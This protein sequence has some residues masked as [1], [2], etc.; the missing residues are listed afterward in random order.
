VNGCRIRTGAIYDRRMR[1]VIVILLTLV[2]GRAH[3]DGDTWLIGPVIGVQLGGQPQS[4]LVIG[5]EGGGGVGPERINLGF[6]H[7]DTKE[8]GYIE[9]DPWYVVGG[10]LGIGVDS[11]A[12]AVPILGL[13]EGLPITSIDGSCNVWHPEITIAGGY[14]YTGAHELYLTMKAGMMNGNVC[15]D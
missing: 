11:D 14:R 9:L 4:R 8:V 13:W 1:T 5:V 15:F 10:T 2:S 6:E 7:R 12:N 3:A